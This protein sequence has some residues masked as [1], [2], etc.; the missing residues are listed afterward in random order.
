VSHGDGGARVC[1]KLK[2][3][4][5]LTLILPDV[6]SEV[7]EGV[8]AAEGPGVGSKRERER[9]K[10]VSHKCTSN[11]SNKNCQSS[12]INLQRLSPVIAYLTLAL[13]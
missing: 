7:G 1:I 9:K 2:L 11:R 8:G 5:Q 12:S 10:R 13:P 6:G 3:E 4:K